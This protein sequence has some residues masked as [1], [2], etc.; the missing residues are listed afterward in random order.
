MQLHFSIS[1][2][3]VVARL[4]NEEKKV[5]LAQQC[6]VQNLC[7][8]ITNL[9][10]CVDDFLTQNQQTM[11]FDAQHVFFAFDEQKNITTARIILSFIA[12]L[13]IAK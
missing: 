7:E 2:G 5:V 6:E 8:N 12:G 3:N 13:N 9:F 1:N 4:Y 10:D 11:P